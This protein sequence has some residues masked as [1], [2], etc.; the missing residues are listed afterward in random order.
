MN[1]F[2]NNSHESRLHIIY[3]L[4]ILANDKE[5][6]ILEKNNYQ[7]DSNIKVTTSA[8]LLHSFKLTRAIG[9]S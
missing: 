5:D 2:H 3:T 4:T 1:Q 7:E 6:L 8:P 9:N